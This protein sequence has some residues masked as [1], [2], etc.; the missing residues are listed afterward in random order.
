MENENKKH[1]KH[2]LNIFIFPVYFYIHREQLKKY[3]Y[4]KCFIYFVYFCEI[5]GTIHLYTII[6]M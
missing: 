2:T 1:L 6:N 4:S 5:K 3:K